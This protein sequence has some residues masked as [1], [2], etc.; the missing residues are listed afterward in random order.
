MPTDLLR[1]IPGPGGPLEARLDLPDGPPRAV[2]VVAHPHPQ[3][4]GTLHT[5]AVHQTAK[6]LVGIGVAALRFNFRGAGLSAGTFDEGA[7]E[8]DDFRA[9]IDFASGRFP[10]LP[11]WAVGMSFGS[12]IATTVGAADPRVRLLLAIAAPANHYEYEALRTSSK[13]KFFIHGEEDEVAPLKSVRKL[14]GE[15]LEPKE[16]AVIEDADHV[17]DGK[18]SLVSDAVEDLLGDYD[19][20]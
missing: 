2:A 20:G 4:G 19:N 8:Q 7:G 3:F 9:A 15:A 17:F 12:W 5:R 13:P 16:L 14:Y 1:E 6:A 11:V 10:G 18:T